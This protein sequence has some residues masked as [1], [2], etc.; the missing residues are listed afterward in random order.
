[1]AKDS[2]AL[3]SLHSII[4]EW[5]GQTQ[6]A[7][8]ERAFLECGGLD[9][10]LDGF[11]FCS[12]GLIC[13]NAKVK[14]KPKRRPAA[15]LQKEPPAIGCSEFVQPTHHRG[16]YPISKSSRG[17]ESFQGLGVVFYAT[18]PGKATEKERILAIF[19]VLLLAVLLSP[20][21]LT[22]ERLKLARQM[23]IT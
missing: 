15:A 16:F 1:M 20:F 7:R 8:A 5:A 9:A 17:V 6:A 11:A 23:L 22:S 10:A 14:N 19:I 12:M 4:D 21:F 18:K 13:G 3:V 2:M